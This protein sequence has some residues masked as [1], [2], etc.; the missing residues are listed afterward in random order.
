MFITANMAKVES[1]WDPPLKLR[2]VGFIISEVHM[3]VEILVFL[4]LIDLLP[5]AQAMPGSSRSRRTS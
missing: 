4:T 2:K 5:H 1:S 3:R